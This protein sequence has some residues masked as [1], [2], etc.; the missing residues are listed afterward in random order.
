MEAMRDAGTPPEYAYAYRKTGL[1][2]LGGD[3][4][5]WPKDRREEWEAAV[6]EYRQMEQ[7]AQSKPNKQSGSI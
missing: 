6:A 3:M 1:L 7:A 5:L 4:S 2:S